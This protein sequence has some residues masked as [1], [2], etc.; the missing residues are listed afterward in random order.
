MKSKFDLSLPVSL[1]QPSINCFDK[2]VDL[3]FLELHWD[4]WVLH[5]PV[6]PVVEPTIVFLQGISSMA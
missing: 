6:G 4:L 5:R 1:G 2:P 3:D